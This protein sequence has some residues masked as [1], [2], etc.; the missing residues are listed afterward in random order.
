MTFMQ[1]KEKPVELETQNAIAI[2]G[3]AC[4]FPGCDDINGFWN[5]L[6]NGEHAISEVPASRW[7]ADSLFSSDNSVPGKM[8]TKWGGFLND[9]SGFDAAL[10]GISNMEA[11]RID[12]QQRILLEMVWCA[13]EDAQLPLQRMKGTKT[14]V[15]VGISTSDY[16][17]LQFQKPEFIDAYAG[18]GN[19]HC[20]AANRIS[21]F[22]DLRGPSFS[23]DT[24]CSSSLVA[25]HLA[26]R[27][28]RSK[29]IDYAI[30]A[31]VNLM[32]KPELTIAF[33]KAGMMSPDGKC[34]AFGDGANGYV[35]G[36]GCG[37]VVLKR[38]DDCATNRIHAI[39]RGTAINQDGRSNGITAPNGPAQEAVIREALRDAGV[40]SSD[41][42]YLEAHG[43]GTPLG[44]PIE[45]HSLQRVLGADK[46][47]FPCMVGS[48]KTNFGHLEAAAGMAGLIKTVLSIKHQVIPPHLN[49]ESLSPHIKSIPGLLQIARKAQPWPVAALKRIAGVSSFGFGGTNGH[50]I[51]EAPPA[52]AVS[53]AGG[54]PTLPHKSSSEILC[55]SAHTQTALR[56]LAGL[57]A[58]MLE[59]NKDID[60]SAVAHACLAGRSHLNH[61]LALASESKDGL[62]ADLHHYSSG[63]EKSEGYRQ[64]RGRQPTGVIGIFPGQGSQYAGLGR[65]L[66]QRCPTV[67]SDF[68]ICDEAFASSLGFSV[69]KEILEGDDRQILHETLY[70]QPILFMTEFAIAKLWQRAGL[71]FSCLLG[72]SLGEY[73]AATISGMMSLADAIKLVSH[74]ARLMSGVKGQAGMLAVVAPIDQLNE[75]LSPLRNLYDIAAIN[76]PAN[77]VL[78]AAVDDLKKIS[79]ALTEARIRHRYLPVSHGFHSRQ[80][81]PILD[82]FESMA[83][84]LQFSLPSIPTLANF[85]GKLHSDKKPVDG[86][87][88]RDHLRH[89]VLFDECIQKTLVFKPKWLVELGPAAGLSSL[90]KHIAG[91]NSDVSAISGLHKDAEWKSLTGAIQK[92][93]LDGSDLSYGAFWDGAGLAENTLPLYPFERKNFWFS[94]KLSTEV[95]AQLTPPSLKNTEQ[96]GAVMNTTMSQGD[97]AK[98]ESDHNIVEKLVSVIAKIMEV[99]PSEVD[100]SAPLLELGADSL[101]LIRAQQEIESYYNVEIPFSRLLDDLG[102]LSALSE[103]IAEIKSTSEKSTGNVS[104]VSSTKETGSGVESIPSNQISIAHASLN[105]NHSGVEA[106]IAQQIDLMQRQLS[107][108]Q[109][110]QSNERKSPAVPA[111][112]ALAPVLAPVEFAQIPAAEKTADE[113]T[114]KRFNRF[115]DLSNTRPE[116]F[117]ETKREYLDFLT[118]EFTEKTNSSKRFAAAYRPALADNRASAGF[119]LST[120]EL[121]YPI[122]GEKAQGSK[123]WDI[124]NNEYVDFTMGF[125]VNFFGHAPKFITSAISRQLELGMFLGPQAS[126][127]GPVS[128]LLCEM[129]GH[130]RVVFCNSGT[131][132]TMTAVRLARAVTGRTKVVIFSGSYHGTFDGLLGQF[133]GGKTV[134]IAPGTPEPMLSDLIVLDYGTDA[135]LQYIEANGQSIAAVMVEPVQSRRPDLQPKEF[136]QRLRAITEKKGTAFIW[137]EIIWGFRLAPA[138]AQEYFGVKADIATYG[139]ILGGGTPIGAI[140][141]SRRYLDAIDGGQWAYGDASL[142]TADTIFFAGTF[143]KNPLAMAASRAVLTQ[144]KKSGPNLQKNLNEKT[145][146]LAG[147]LNSYFQSNNC[148][149][150]IKHCGSLFRFSFKQNLDLLFYRLLS[151]GL[152][153][154]E[155]RNCFMSTEHSDQDIQHLIRSVQETIGELGTS[156]W[157]PGVSGSTTP[158]SHSGSRKLLKPQE[159]FARLAAHGSLGANVGNLKVGIRL[160]GRLNTDFLQSAV[161]EVVNRHE[162][163]RSRINIAACTQE[164]VNPFVVP[165]EVISAE[166][167]DASKQRVIEQWVNMQSAMPTHVD[168]T[169][170]LF[171]ISL[172]QIDETDHVLLVHSH[173]LICDGISLGLI[174]EEIA[175]IYSSRIKQSDPQ[176]MPA[177]SYFQSMAEIKADGMSEKEKRYW[178]EKSQFFASNELIPVDRLQSEGYAASR[179]IRDM[180]E[181]FKPASELALQ[182]GVTPYTVLLGK[183][184]AAMGD[185]AKNNHVTIAIP[186]AG[187][188][189][190]RIDYSV[191]GDCTTLLPLNVNLATKNDAELFKQVRSELIKAVDFESLNYTILKEFIQMESGNNGLLPFAVVFNFDKY[192]GVP[193][194]AE[195]DAEILQVPI[196]AVEFPIVVD[197]QVVGEAANIVV[198]YANEM[199]AADQI[200]AL[201]DRYLAKLADSS[202][203]INALSTMAA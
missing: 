128:S 76:S 59:K 19:S 61:R 39:V 140:A 189:R 50:V 131:E 169:T 146:W 123:I 38:M 185:F 166:K 173:H 99:E 117:T 122:V 158:S 195:L 160:R 118:K 194:F 84:S 89:T 25:L 1:K 96:L 110:S 119:R 127:A 147:E 43:T 42:A 151:K 94:P 78:A 34:N 156:G 124:D 116:S 11:S 52:L 71:R 37:V 113:N 4:R 181:F 98:K 95:P 130:D 152:Y 157:L 192:D 45:F 141:G 64:V 139:K 133:F 101:V 162:I 16:S 155:G 8:S 40:I 57:Y 103:Y 197:I 33:S 53:N 187:K 112:M 9:V 183:F 136:L 28:L 170:T 159:R 26:V 114:V 135:A 5:L 191:V 137:D 190:R 148:P 97:V 107:L 171:R 90:A 176:L 174:V 180:S 165:F 200:E 100:V 69:L 22:F 153:I 179:Y 88:W 67:R 134:S 178:R 199:I 6:V 175:A 73:V 30:V 65:E 12:P 92:F 14:G 177:M 49:C 51:V 18:T 109:G 104:V 86:K 149:I 120:K 203:E 186:F 2:V 145:S 56:R 17:S 105:T 48:V 144:L 68:H 27:A 154:W 20:I 126:D 163:L 46:R 29:E 32:L 164:I 31:G 102:T 161:Q 83:N 13:L 85:T 129:T 3:M 121:I 41:L 80:L 77:I 15:Y 167:S 63:T 91:D 62:I 182:H 36:E 125:G 138:G 196:Q 79:S 55:I 35:R 106:V 7:S 202:S 75:I 115:S 23:V 58:T 93:Y 150:S 72:H 74:R 47:T 21:Y 201:V 66:Y 44:D 87:Y 54:L 60:L 193:P 143:S 172:L 108:L 10:F 81:D 184:A 111:P 132:A 198:T 142:P 24:A 82:E 168:E 70:A 188:A